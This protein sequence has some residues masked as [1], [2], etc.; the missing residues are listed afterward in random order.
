MIPHLTAALVGY[1][2]GSIPFGYLVARMHGVN[3]F[4]V[5]SR[6][7]GA[8]NVKR[9]LGSKAGN[10][11]FALDVL[12]GAV[13]AA[14]AIFAYLPISVHYDLTPWGLD[15]SG[16]VDG[17]LWLGVG[18]SGLI[19]A[20]LG[21]SFSVFTRFR[22]GKGVATGAGGFLVLA[23]LVA[24][25]AVLIWVATFYLSRYVSLASI[26]AALALPVASISLGQPWSVTTLGLLVAAFVA[27]RHRANIARLRAGTESKFARKTAEARE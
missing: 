8:T 3:I 21:H 23:P 15:A 14:W 18:I 16:L 4:E 1:L 20:L 5:G 26:L 27:Y 25:I 6:N 17:P 12:K 10:T 22:G 9:V 24:I 13:A 19:G 2:L 7:P 11:V